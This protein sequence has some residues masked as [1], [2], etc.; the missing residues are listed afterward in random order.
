MTIEPRCAMEFFSDRKSASALA[1][2]AK[3]QF[4][5]S[6]IP[7]A[8]KGWEV[9]VGGSRTGKVHWMPHQETRIQTLGIQ[10]D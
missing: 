1:V 2:V 3:L 8:L 4:Y 10:W 6:A 5:N 9:P 7:R